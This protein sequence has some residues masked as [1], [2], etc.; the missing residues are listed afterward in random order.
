MGQLKN[1]DVLEQLD[2]VPMVGEGNQEFISDTSI[3]RLMFKAACGLTG[4]LILYQHEFSHSIYGVA[5]RLLSTD[6]DELSQDVMGVMPLSSVHMLEP[7]WHQCRHGFN[8]CTEL[9]GTT[10]IT[11]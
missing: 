7:R 5:P 2:L 10:P 8:I 1:P 11:S 9:S 3:C 6:A 4:D